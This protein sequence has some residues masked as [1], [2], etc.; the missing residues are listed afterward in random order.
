MIHRWF[1]AERVVVLV[2]V[3][4]FGLAAASCAPDPVEP[5]PVGPTN[6]WEVFQPRPVGYDLRAVWGDAPSR[7]WAVGARGVIVHW[8]GRDVREVDSPTRVGL[9]S[10]VARTADDIYAAGGDLVLHYDGRTWDIYDRFPDQ[11][12]R[13]LCLLD[14]G[15]LFLVGSM[16]LMVREADGWRTLDGP[17]MNSRVVWRGPDGRLRV[18]E[19][20]TIWRL[21]GD[22]ATVERQF[23]G[24]SVHLGSGR[25]VAV[26]TD[27]YDRVY[28]LEDGTWVE[29]EVGLLWSLHALVDQGG[30]ITSTNGGIS[31]GGVR[32]WTNDSG[33]WV[34]GLSACGDNGLLACGY[35]GTLMHTPSAA[36]DGSAVWNESAETL[37]YRHANA[38][39]GT[40]C[41]D[42]WMAEWYSRVLHFDGQLW[43]C[44]FTDLR[45]DLPVDDIQTFD[46]GWVAATD[47]H[48][49]VLRD[50]DG[51]WS[52][53]PEPGPGLLT[54][55]AVA[56]DDVFASSYDGVYHWDG[57]VWT[58]HDLGDARARALAITVAREVYALV[59]GAA[60][61]LQRWDGAEFAV[62]QAVPGVSGHVLEASRVD[63]TLWIVGHT[64]GE[65]RRS[66]IYRFRDGALA[67]VTG[68]RMFAAHPAQLTE[69][70]P[71]D[72]FLLLDDQVWRYCDGV[73]SRESGLPWGES[74]DVIW[75]HP[76]CGVFVNGHPTFFKAY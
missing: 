65:T 69:L 5:L 7:I 24:V 43:E 31:A 73:W 37:G 29:D 35:G 50:P 22:L 70:R 28:R 18:G 4:A 71:D 19:G 14:D 25:Y 45:G 32:I 8:D 63:E 62:V 9:T 58:L 57:A 40:G 12:V 68:G 15:R 38:F 61:T 44:I 30:L 54:F 47:N 67:E 75:S 56:A 17:G 1:R 27:D 2:S 26:G 11:T 52:L 49:I 21:S 46:D 55:L 23:D 34:Y 3:V 10:I 53:L 36:S 39:C 48:R 64:D 60:T 51:I 33:R 42:I 59:V 72:L 76:D 6:G 74:L 20:G 13:Q 66:R 16:G 41:D